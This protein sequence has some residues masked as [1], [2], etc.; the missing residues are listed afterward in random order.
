MFAFAAVRVN[1]LFISLIGAGSS[2]GFIAGLIAGLIV[3]L[4]V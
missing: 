4:I 2:G 1:D 3:G